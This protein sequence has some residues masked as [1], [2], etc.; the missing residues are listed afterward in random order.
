MI[1]PGMSATGARPPAAPGPHAGLHA[2]MLAFLTC[3]AAIDGLTPTDSEALLDALWAHT[4]ALP[5]WHHDW[6][7]G[8]T[9]VWDNRFT[10]H[11]R[12][13]FDAQAR[14]IMHRTQT[15]GS[16]PALI[17]SDADRHPR[18]VTA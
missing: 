6:A 5:A 11:H 13:A 14:R 10:I 3:D 7:V 12:N 1:S 16:A 4:A 15:K 18:A 2:T 9:V 8:D 17:R